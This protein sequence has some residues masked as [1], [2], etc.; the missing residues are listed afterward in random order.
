[1][2]HLA[3]FLLCLWIFGLAS[4]AAQAANTETIT[5]NTAGP[6][7]SLVVELAVTAAERER[8]LMFREDFAPGDAMLFVFPAPKRLSFWMKNTP[9]SLDIVYFDASGRWLNTHTATTPF[10]LDNLY[11]S[12]LAR[13]ALELAAGEVARLQIGQGTRLIRGTP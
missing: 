4:Y 1:M 9:V 3:R 2:R 10:S 7:H 8:G 6:S 5:L 12:G 11:S 13:Y